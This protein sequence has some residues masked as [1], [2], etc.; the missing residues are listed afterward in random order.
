[1]RLGGQIV[2]GHRAAVWSGS[3]SAL[4]S[5]SIT[6]HSGSDLLDVP[7]LTRLKAL[8]LTD[9]S[10]EGPDKLEALAALKQLTYFGLNR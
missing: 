2:L 3:L 8:R 4:T 7:H 10:C 6:V 5:L 1:V 9:F